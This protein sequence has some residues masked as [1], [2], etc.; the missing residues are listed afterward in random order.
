MEQWSTA[1]H[2]HAAIHEK[3][4]VPLLEG[5]VF[6]GGAVMLTECAEHARSAGQRPILG[7]VLGAA[8]AAVAFGQRPDLK[9]LL[10]K[11]DPAIVRIESGQ[12]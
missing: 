2:R 1:E 10:A 3:R 4:R 12:R 11:V 9:P 6:A 7:L 8:W 5:A